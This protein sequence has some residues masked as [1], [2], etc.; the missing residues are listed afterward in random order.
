[1]GRKPGALDN[2]A[3]PDH[4]SGHGDPDRPLLEASTYFPGRLT[5]AG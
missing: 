2:I 3:L 1:M 5:R 4:F